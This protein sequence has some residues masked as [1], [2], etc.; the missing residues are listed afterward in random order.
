MAK[1]TPPNIHSVKFCGTNVSRTTENAILEFDTEEAVRL[2]TNG[3]RTNLNSG[4]VR[5]SL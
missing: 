4:I 3:D 2:Q 1:K 5:G